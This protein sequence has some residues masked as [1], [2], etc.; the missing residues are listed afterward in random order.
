MTRLKSFE[1]RSRFIQTLT[2]TKTVREIQNRHFNI[3]FK[4][5]S[6]NLNNNY[7]HFI[8]LCYHFTFKF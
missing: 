1:L 4:D 2:R 5:F 3:Q 7:R 8:L 6:F